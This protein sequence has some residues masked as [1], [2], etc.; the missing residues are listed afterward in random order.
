MLINIIKND[1]HKPQNI[2]KIILRLQKWAFKA[3]QLSVHAWRA[4]KHLSINLSSFSVHF[5]LNCIMLHHLF[6]L[7]LLFVEL[8]SLCYHFTNVLFILK[9]Q[10]L[11]KP[12]LNFIKLMLDVRKI[13][14]GNQ[15]RNFLWNFSLLFYFFVFGCECLL[16]EILDMLG[17]FIEGSKYFF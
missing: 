10:F 1:L 7:K 8:Y 6:T 15:Q 3:Y 12:S 13:P 5:M 9:S 17:M 14:T 2:S 16:L 11:N 4:F